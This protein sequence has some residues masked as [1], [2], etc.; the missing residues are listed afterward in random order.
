MTKQPEVK[1]LW[2]HKT[3]TMS[4]VIETEAR[5]REVIAS[6]STTRFFVRD[7]DQYPDMTI[8]A[9]TGDVVD[10]WHLI[11]N[12][13]QPENYATHRL[14]PPFMRDIEPLPKEES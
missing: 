1:V 11:R 9:I 8:R 13:R 2:G 7:L 5:G 12:G 4:W 3:R 14:A 10:V 6:A